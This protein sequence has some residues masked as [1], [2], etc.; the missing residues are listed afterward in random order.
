MHEL[1]LYELTESTIS[2]GLISRRTFNYYKDIKLLTLQIKDYPDYQ[3]RFFTWNRKY[4]WIGS[5]HHNVYNAPE[6]VKIN[7]D[8]IHY[9][10]EGKNRKELERQW[11]TMQQNTRRIYA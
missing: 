9:E 10:K 7:K 3:P 4:K 2:Y 5:P 11:S 8:I 1:Y 6:P